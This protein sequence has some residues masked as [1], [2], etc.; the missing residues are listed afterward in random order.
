MLDMMTPVTFVAAAG[1]QGGMA[2]MM[3]PMI[4][5]FGIMYFMIIRP[6]QR[7]EKQRR[8]MIQ[9]VKSGERV[10]FGG[11]IIGT[12]TNVKEGTLI[13][14]IADNVKIEVARGSVSRVLDKGEKVTAEDEK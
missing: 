2:G 10:I 1:P 5:I 14:K 9:N 6:Q 11:G 3:V 8:E 13:V 4:I 7:K 12:I